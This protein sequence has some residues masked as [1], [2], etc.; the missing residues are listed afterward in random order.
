[1]SAC[2]RIGGAPGATATVAATLGPKKV[3]VRVV[4]LV[5]ASRTVDSRRG[6]P[7]ASGRPLPTTVWYPAND[8]ASGAP[9][10]TAGA[11]YPL[12]VFSHG[13]RG[14]PD[15]YAPLLRS[16][17]AQGYV[18]AAPTFPLTN[19]DA[20]PVVAGDLANQPADVSFVISSLLASSADT[21]DPF[22]GAIDPRRVIAA[23]HSEGALT[24]VMLFA[25]CCV[26]ARLVGAIVM[27]G[28]DV[29]TQG[30]AFTAPPKPLLYI[31][32]DQDKIVSYELGQRSYRG[33]PDPKAFL[34]LVGAGHID[35]YVRE[36]TGPA[37]DAV[38][39]ATAAFLAYLTGPDRTSAHAA[40]RAVGARTGVATL[41]DR[42]P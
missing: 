13:L 22:A 3:A 26:E 18:V 14:T 1:V 2:G 27:A 37:G 39:S 7:A 33:A 31:H 40:L 25:Q 30:R 34:T 28:D 12:V 32:G 9:L 41:D 24:T 15:D 5:D 11:P 10:N 4:Q 8:T 38:R 42:L 20:E 21:K 16:W 36:A 6:G 23:G 35:P 17:A 19:R 29:G